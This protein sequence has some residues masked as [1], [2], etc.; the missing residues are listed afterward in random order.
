MGKESYLSG[1]PDEGFN[2][3]YDFT[4]NQTDRNHSINKENGDFF[5]V[6]DK[7]FKP[8]RSDAEFVKNFRSER[9]SG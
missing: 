4:T 7:G 8:M 2:N 9:V 1:L 3:L 6:L 5:D